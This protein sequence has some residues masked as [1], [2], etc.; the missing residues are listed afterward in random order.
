MFVFLWCIIK[1][2]VFVMCCIASL[3][4]ICLSPVYV[5]RECNNQEAT[6]N[7]PSSVDIKSVVLFI[8]VD[9]LRIGVFSANYCPVVYIF[10][11]SLGRPE[12]F[13]KV[14]KIGVGCVFGS[15]KS[16]N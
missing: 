2:N 9:W 14:A 8:N 5:S 11:I 16:P 4:N 1:R 7:V 12:I 10:S 13:E 3:I 6:I 15:Y